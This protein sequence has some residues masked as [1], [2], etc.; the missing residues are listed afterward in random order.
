MASYLPSLYSLLSSFF[1]NT[2]VLKALLFDLDGTLADTDHLHEQ[3]WLEALKPYGIQ[4]DHHFYQ[5]QISGGVNPEIAA[6]ILPQLSPGEAKAFLDH[7][8]EHFRSLATALQPMPGLQRLLDWATQGRLKLALVSNA[9]RENVS[10]MLER[11]GLEFPLKILSD[12]LGVG[13][14]DPLP[15]QVALERLGLEASQALAFEDSP[16]GVR[17]AKGAGIGTIAITSGH[18]P[19]ALAQAG[20]DLLVPNFEHPDLWEYL[21]QQ[22]RK[23]N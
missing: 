21:H 4:A 8:E 1:Y 5:T 3:A 18:N 15:Y 10:Y 9:P 6:R 7:K 12:D 13:K 2:Q 16:T 23:E 17:A 14:P 19:L 22:D 20:A 11:L